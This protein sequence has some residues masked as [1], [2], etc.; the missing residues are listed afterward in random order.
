MTCTK[1]AETDGLFVI[2]GI[3]CIKSTAVGPNEVEV[4][5]KFGGCAVDTCC[6][7]CLDGGE[8]HRAGDDFRVI[9]NGIGVDWFEEDSITVLVGDF[10]DEVCGALLE[11]FFGIA[12]ELSRRGAGGTGGGHLRGMRWDEELCT[13]FGLWRVACWSNR[14]GNECKNTSMTSLG[15]SKL[16]KITEKK[17]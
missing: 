9:G 6:E 3:V 8:V 4:C 13:D 7:V 2:D 16:W 1:S 10:A 12:M 5:A 11:E 17:N 15:Y 14:S